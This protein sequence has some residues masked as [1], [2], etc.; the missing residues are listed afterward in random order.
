MRPQPHEECPYQRFRINK[1]K[2]P[3]AVEPA[4]EAPEP[5][6]KDEGGTGGGE[7]RAE[8]VFQDPGFQGVPTGRENC[9]GKAKIIHTNP[10]QDLIYRRRS[11]RLDK[12]LQGLPINPVMVLLHEHA[13][14]QDLKDVDL[15]VGKMRGGMLQQEQGIEIRE[16]EK[17]LLAVDID[18]LETLRSKFLQARF[19]DLAGRVRMSTHEIVVGLKLLDFK[20][21]CRMMLR[22]LV[23]DSRNNMTHYPHLL[24]REENESAI[25][26]QFSS[27]YFFTL[28]LC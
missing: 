3:G 22:G 14:V 1:P 5:L 17:C 6:G 27:S 2:L 4:A 24:H 28:Y 26:Q 21:E 7:F 15:R 11:G 19:H 8:D 18:S 13:P 20:M 23:P 25:P 12:G 10:I 16:R 9:R